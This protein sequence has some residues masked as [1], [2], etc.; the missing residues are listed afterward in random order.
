MCLFFTYY[1][2]FRDTEISE[3]IIDSVFNVLII[4]STVAASSHAWLLQF[5][6]FFIH[7]YHTKCRISRWPQLFEKNPTQID[8]QTCM[9]ACIYLFYPCQTHSEWQLM[10]K[11][12]KKKFLAGRPRRTKRPKWKLVSESVPNP[13][14][15]HF[16][17]FKLVDS[18]TKWVKSAL[19]VCGC[20]R[21]AV[22]YDAAKRC[23]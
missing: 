19:H 9:Y 2:Y 18:C 10:A 21:Y 13:F 7:Y 11:I 3:L 8:I 16:L 1:K 15:L 17:S 14:R 12:A 5:S 6:T 23:V 4:H 22:I 20:V